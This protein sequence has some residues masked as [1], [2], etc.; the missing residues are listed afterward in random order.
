[1]MPVAPTKLKAAGA[2][3]DQSGN[4]AW[5][6]AAEP[7]Q[8]F[9]A[10]N[11]DHIA[12]GWLKTATRALV[13]LLAVADGSSMRRRAIA[14]LRVCSTSTEL[15]FSTPAVE[16]LD[17]VFLGICRKARQRSCTLCRD[18]G[19]PARIRLIGEDQSVTQCTRCV[20]PALLKH[21]IWELDQS[22]RF[23]KA[24]G[25]PISASQIPPLLR[26]SFLE[27]SAREPVS[28][29]GKGR[30]DQMSIAAFANWAEGWRRIGE[31]LAVVH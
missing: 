5:I 12:P 11:V 22:L 19:R 15:C 13:K 8:T 9:M 10:L 21:E 26:P 20:A 16:S 2:R 18:C 1:M 27:A 6:D 3:G 28:T 7:V 31:G 17:E 29:E 4:V 14:S 24:V 30:S 23:L 25:R